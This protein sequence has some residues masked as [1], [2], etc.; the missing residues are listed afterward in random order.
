MSDTNKLL[1]SIV[2]RLTTNL[3]KIDRVDEVL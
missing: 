1:L 3:D 2:T